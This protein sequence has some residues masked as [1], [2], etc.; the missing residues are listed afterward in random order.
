MKQ[1]GTRE[2]IQKVKCL[3]C[4][5]ED[6]GWDPEHPLKNPGMNREACDLSAGKPVVGRFL[7]LAV[8]S[9]WTDQ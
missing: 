8:L 1:I 5:P 3:P 4:N 7:W 2:M 6:L 9:A